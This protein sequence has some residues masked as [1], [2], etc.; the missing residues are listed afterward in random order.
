MPKLH[1]PPNGPTNY[2]RWSCSRAMRPPLRFSHVFTYRAPL[3]SPCWASG[4][5]G[6]KII[7]TNYYTEVEKNIVCLVIAVVSVAFPVVFSIT[8][9]PP[10]HLDCWTHCF[11][12]RQSGTLADRARYRAWRLARETPKNPKQ[13]PSR[14]KKMWRLLGKVVGLCFWP[15]C[16][17]TWDTKSRWCINGFTNIEGVDGSDIVFTPRQ[18]QLHNPTTIRAF[19]DVPAPQ[20]QGEIFKRQL[21][22]VACPWGFPAKSSETA[23]PSKVKQGH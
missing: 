5:T 15:F 3:I 7:E 14:T 4:S 23:P 9:V 16:N 18:S 22:R 17:H 8:K 2:K 20:P 12:T 13:R 21:G 1:K 6:D 11:L 19:T 10:F